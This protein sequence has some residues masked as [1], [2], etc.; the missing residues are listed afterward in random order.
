MDILFKKNE[1]IKEDFS[2]KGL[3]EAKEK[4]DLMKLPAEQRKAYEAYQDDL[5]YQASMFESN[6]GEGY[7]DGVDENIR[8]TVLRMHKKGLDIEMI[9]EIAGIAQNDVKNILN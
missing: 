4:L 8:Q 9:A 5:H 2:A 1:E 6:Y 7:L 3:L